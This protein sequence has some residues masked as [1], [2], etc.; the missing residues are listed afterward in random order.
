MKRIIS[1]GGTLLTWLYVNIGLWL[2]RFIFGGS[3]SNETMFSIG[4]YT[5]GA[6]LILLLFSKKAK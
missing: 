4:F 6:M 3:I 5:L 1:L 2:G